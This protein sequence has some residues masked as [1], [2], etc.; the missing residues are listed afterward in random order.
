M[1]NYRSK[2]N[3]FKLISQPEV[4]YLGSRKVEECQLK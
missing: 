2:T 4:G 3:I 1:L